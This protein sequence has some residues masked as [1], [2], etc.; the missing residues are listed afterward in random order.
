M[1][2]SILIATDGSDAAHVAER[3]GVS[4]AARLKTRCYGLTVVEERVTLGLRADSLGVPPGPLDAVENF[5]KMRAEAAC[6][7]LAEHARAQSVECAPEAVRGPGT[8]RERGQRHRA[9]PAG[10]EVGGDFVQQRLDDTSR[11]VDER[12]VL[13]PAPRVVLRSAVDP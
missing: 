10:G 2:E 13:V 8:A 4:F 3:F 6:R 12:P 5:L 9:Q 1:I 11:A 7:R